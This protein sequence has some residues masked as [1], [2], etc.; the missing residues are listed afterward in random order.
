MGLAERPGRAA[1]AACARAS[2][3]FPRSHGRLAIRMGLIA[4]RSP[5]HHGFRRAHVHAGRDEFV[6]RW[7]RRRHCRSTFAMLL[8]IGLSTADGLPVTHRKGMSPN[9]C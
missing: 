1:L 5:A 9:A 7:S 3:N 2:S 4:S 6:F 8:R